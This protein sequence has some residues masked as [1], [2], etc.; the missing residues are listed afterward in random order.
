MKRTMKAK[1]DD[2]HGEIATIR[3]R[4]TELH[5]ER[6]ELAFEALVDAVVWAPTNCCSKG[7][8]LFCSS[9]DKGNTDD[10]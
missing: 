4:R 6:E 10:P 8:V 7:S 2:L 9:D 5:A 1:I 3:G